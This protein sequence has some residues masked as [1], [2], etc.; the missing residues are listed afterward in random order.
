MRIKTKALIFSA[1]IKGHY[2]EYIHHIYHLCIRKEGDF[3]FY[4]PEE[5]VLLKKRLEWKE[6]ENISFVYISNKQ[7]EYYTSKNIIN[8]SKYL[9]ELLKEQIINY[10]ISKI[11]CCTLIQIL[12]FAPFLLPSSV[13]VSGIIYM[14]YL[15]RWKELSI[16]GKIQNV[17]KYLILSLSSKFD[18]IYILNDKKNANRFN[19][20]YHTKKFYYLPD[21]YVPIVS[22]NNVMNIRKEFHI[23]NG[24]KIII[25]FGALNENKGTL[26]LMNSLVCLPVELNQK[27]HFVL[28]GKIDDEIKE[29]FYNIYNEIKER[30]NIT[31]IDKFCSY[32]FLKDLCITSDAIVIPYKRTAQSSG[33]I[34]YASQFGKP[35]IAPSSG[36]LGRLVKEYKLGIVVPEITSESLI[37][38]YRTIIQGHYKNPN[39][40][41][42]RNHTV[43]MFQD[44]ISSCL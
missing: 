26:D 21:P 18:Y 40:N 19:K 22:N 12:P 31:I 32:E 23:D 36:L 17:I 27:V 24:H 42:C 35:V 33:V 13:K 9:C 8:R 39:D 14:I 16:V 25:H 10:N 3:L 28:A 15:Y 37:N 44:V 34:G 11:F 7:Y 38:A 6:A 5:F 2:L 43:M 41:Y 29:V 1:E 20:L 4:V 30:I